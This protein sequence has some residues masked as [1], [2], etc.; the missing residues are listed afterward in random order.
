V[1]RVGVDLK[2]IS[3]LQQTLEANVDARH[4]VPKTQNT[5]SGMT[6]ILVRK[7]S[8][9]TL[10]AIIAL[11]LCGKDIVVLPTDD[12]IEMRHADGNT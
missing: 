5:S 12:L 6:G 8:S 4:T 3:C 9:A 7:P 2:V 11:A 1:L 10:P